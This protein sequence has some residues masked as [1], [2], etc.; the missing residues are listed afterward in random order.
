MIVEEK[1]AILKGSPIFITEGGYEFDEINIVYETYGSLN[2]NKDNVILIEHA[3]SGSAHAAGVHPGKRNRG[4]WDILIGPDKHIDT[5][6][7]FVICSNFIGSCYGTTGPSS[8]DPVTGNPYG[9][10]FPKVNIRDMVRVQKLLL[11][12]LGIDHIKAVVGGSMGGMQALEWAVVYPDLVDKSIVIAAD[13]KLTPLNIAYNYI[14]IQS[15]LNDPNFNNGDYYDMQ[16]KPEIGLKNARMLGMI[17][18]KSGDL[19]DIR[20]KRSRDKKNFAIENYLNYQG[21]SFI[22]RFDANSYLYVLWAMNEHDITKPYGSLKTALKRIKSQILMIGIDKDMIFPSKY[23]KDFI[24]KLNSQGGFGKFKEI[25]SI[26]GHDSFLIDFNKIGPIIAD[27]I[28]EMD[29]KKEEAI[30]I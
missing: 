6:K 8:I 3:L 23:M 20:F 4:W 16:N 19:F 30:C 1:K 5:N 26:H 24:K 29:E 27:F 10:R 14:G 18:Y 7:Y 28:Q 9:L 22:D 15:I 21:D 2:N 11:D 25:S 12:Y 13:Y 17:T